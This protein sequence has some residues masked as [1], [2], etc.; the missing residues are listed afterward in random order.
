M[1]L[2]RAV[3]FGW[4]WSREVSR[5]DVMSVHNVFSTVIGPSLERLPLLELSQMASLNGRSFVVRYTISKNVL[6]EFDRRLSEHL[7]AIRAGGFPGVTLEIDVTD[8]ATQESWRPSPDQ[9]VKSVPHA[10]KRVAEYAIGE[11]KRATLT[12]LPG[13]R[14]G[15][16][17]VELAGQKI[18]VTPERIEALGKALDLCGTLGE[19][20]FL[21]ISADYDRITVQPCGTEMRPVTIDLDRGTVSVPAIDGQSGPFEGSLFSF[22]RELAGNRAASA[23]VARARHNLSIAK[24]DAISRFR[25]AAE[26]RIMG[27]DRALAGRPLDSFRL[28]AAATLVSRLKAGLGDSLLGLSEEAQITALEWASSVSGREVAVRTG[29]AGDPYPF[30]TRRIGGTV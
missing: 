17:P 10:L 7:A 16:A 1:Y 2:S 4:L 9:Y 13:G 5:G 11:R 26:E 3:G 23:Y 28:E 24:E 21:Q 18:D 20:E 29:T 22:T 14:G 19:F 15:E 25:S 12:L 27:F 6:T 30:R 8:L